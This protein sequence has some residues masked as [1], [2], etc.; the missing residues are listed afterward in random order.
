MA[1]RRQGPPEGAPLGY[2]PAALE[3]L[4]RRAGL[5]VV[6]HPRSLGWYAVLWAE[7]FLLQ[8]DGP[9]AGRS[10][11]LT[12]EQIRFLVRWFDTAEDGRWIWRSGVLRRMKGWGKDP[13]GAVVCLVEFVGPC[14]WAGEVAP[15]GIRMG[16]SHA[17]PSVSTAAVSRDQTRNTMRLLPGMVGPELQRA[18][19][20]EAGKEIA[21]ARLGR[22]VLESVTNSPTTME[23]RRDSFVLLNETQWWLSNNAGHEMAGVIAGNLAKSRDGSARSLAICNAHVPGEDS[24]AERDYE[25]AEAMRT[26]RTRAAGLL[27]DSVEAPADTDMAD[28]GSL[29]AGLI[30]ARGDSVWLDLDRIMGEIRDPRT[31]AAESRRKYLNQV[32]AAEDAW[33][34]PHEWDRLADATV[35]VPDGT[36]ITL[37][38]DGAKSDDDC[39]LIGCDVES[40]HLFAIGVWS[41]AMHGGEAPRT[42]ID[43]AVRWAFDRWDVVGFYSDLYPWES[44][45]DAWAES[46]G[47]GLAVR[48]AGRHPIAWDMRGRL[49]QFTLAAEALHDAIV[50]GRLTHD[51]DARVRR[52]VHNARRRPNRWGVSLGKEHR[53]SARKVDSVPAAVLAALARREYLALSPGRRRKRQ[54]SGRVV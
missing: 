31:P 11:R 17:A 50:E 13:L 35:V 8:P 5:A 10:L 4:A 19:Q 29:R 34:A 3:D 39:A 25:A 45:V 22:A 27:Y 32:V 53:E 43:A 41:P 6:A 48:A 54:R 47:D 52:H 1:R 37:G 2:E 23:G 28:D 46:F 15:T 33:I 44:Y 12:G 30:V 16:E 7:R 26:G 18:E 51:G 20:L 24:V 9:D 40:G 49:Q 42:E 21:Y 38:F 36:A 14:R